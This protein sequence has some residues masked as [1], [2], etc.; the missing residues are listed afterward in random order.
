[1]TG[2]NL[3]VYFIGAGPGDPELITLK[4]RRLLDNADV[5]IYAKSLVN[6]ELLKGI[7]AEIFDSSRMTLDKIIGII[8]ASIR[9]G[10]SVVRLHSGDP[11]LYS[12]ISEQIERLRELGI[13]YDVVPGVSSAMAGAAVLGQELTIPELTQTVIFT[14][15]EG[16][17]PVPHTEKLSE[18]ARH[19]STMVIF[20]SAGMI[21]KVK[22][23]L[24][25][26]YSED[27]PVVVIEKVSWPEERI[28]RGTLKDI[29]DLVRKADI[30]KTALIYVGE[31]LRAGEESLKKESRLYHK[32]FRHGYRDC[33]G[34]K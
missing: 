26:G 29:V 34:R 20:L 27:T 33:R 12:A 4:G 21:E 23:E 3:K 14:R 19:K 6:P 7:K 2:D 32:D 13:D 10:K 28:I 30:K 9:Q 18:L 1:M 24:L 5:V 16:R 31:A 15:I 25:N 22:D 8:K 17:T 11:A